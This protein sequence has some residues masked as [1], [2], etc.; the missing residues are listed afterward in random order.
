MAEI[1]GLILNF[2]PGR[3]AQGMAPGFIFAS[4]WILFPLRDRFGPIPNLP[5]RISEMVL[6]RL[7]PRDLGIIIPVHFL[8]SLVAAV[9]LRLFLPLHLV[10]PVVYSED[11]LW[12]VDL[13]REILVNAAFSVSVLAGTEFLSLNKIPRSFLPLFLL[14]LYLYGV[15]ADGRA[16]TFGPNV[17]YALRCVTV[18]GDL[19]IRQSSH[20]LGPLIGGV[21]GGKIMALFFPDDP[22]YR[23]HR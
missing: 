20:F 2:L 16:S 22:R 9:I 5:T 23:V 3:I 1:A 13:T 8:A 18:K 19:P 10:A 14:P 7:T 15:D 6:G 21:L 12:L 4:C 11:S 17:L